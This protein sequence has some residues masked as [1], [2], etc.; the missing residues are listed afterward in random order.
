MK[1]IDITKH[2]LV[3]KHIILSEKNKEQLLKRYR[4]SLGHLPRISSSDPVIEAIGGNVGDVVKIMRKSQTA[5][6]SVYYRVVIKG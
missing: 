2:E 1:K 5:G 4:I 3:P 6:Q